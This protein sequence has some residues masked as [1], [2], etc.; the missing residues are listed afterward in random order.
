MDFFYKIVSYCKSFNYVVKEVNG[1][2][3]A[4]VPLVA[5]FGFNYVVKEVSR[6]LVVEVYGL[7]VAGQCLKTY[8]GINHHHIIYYLIK[9][10]LQG[11]HSIHL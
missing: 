3:I 7:L 6:M 5:Q 4:E 10:P 8:V 11:V 2:P 1:I 9:E